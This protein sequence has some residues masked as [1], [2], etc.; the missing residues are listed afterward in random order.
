MKI[1]IYTYIPTDKKIFLIGNVS[2]ILSF[3]KDVNA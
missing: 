1:Y 2:N 3:Y